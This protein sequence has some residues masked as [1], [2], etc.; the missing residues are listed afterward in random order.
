MILNTCEVGIII[1]PIL[2]MGKIRFGEGKQEFKMM[3]PKQQQIL[4]WFLG[5]SDSRA[6][7][8]K[9]YPL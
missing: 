1:I 5:L 2:Q 6:C 9:H 3:Q 8:L 4:D 7:A